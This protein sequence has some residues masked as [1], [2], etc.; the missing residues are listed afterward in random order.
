[1]TI[2]TITNHRVEIDNV[3]EECSARAK[4][5]RENAA[6]SRANAEEM[7]NFAAEYEAIANAAPSEKPAVSV[8]LVGDKQQRRAQA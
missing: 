3:R 8:S 2:R 4:L 7:E 5:L 6:L 1:M